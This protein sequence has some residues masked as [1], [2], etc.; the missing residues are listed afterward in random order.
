MTVNSFVE[1]IYILLCALSFYEIN[2]K[3][4]HDEF[5][6]LVFTNLFK[7]LMYLDLR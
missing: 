5:V 2:T 6:N 7:I 4:N 3:R 1:K